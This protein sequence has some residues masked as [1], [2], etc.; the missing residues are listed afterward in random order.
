LTL[1]G[2]QQA[3]LTSGLATVGVSSAALLG[4]VM[5]HCGMGGTV[6][7]QRGTLVPSTQMIQLTPEGIALQQDGGDITAT[8]SGGDVVI[9]SAG[10]EVSLVGTSVSVEALESITLAVEEN[11]I[12]I[13]STGI[14][15]SG[16]NT[17]IQSEVQTQLQAVTAQLN[18][19]AEW[20]SSI[21]MQLFGS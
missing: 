13:N 16:L 4:N 21:A 3:T 19:Q 17:K 1:S 8:A 6:T 2:T 9:T 12:T 10:G 11:S 5:I 18:V 14:T 20:I 7:L 15:I